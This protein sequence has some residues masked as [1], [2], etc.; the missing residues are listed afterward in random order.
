MLDRVNRETGFLKQ[1]FGCFAFEGRHWGG[2]P[3]RKSITTVNT[4][5]AAGCPGWMSLP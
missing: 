5:C 1:D 2:F 4:F 3:V